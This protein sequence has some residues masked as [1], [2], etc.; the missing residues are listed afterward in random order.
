MVTGTGP[1]GSRGKILVVALVALV[2]LAGCATLVGDDGGG[3]GVDGS[4]S[5]DEG[6]GDV[7]GE[8]AGDVDSFDYPAGYDAD[9]VDDGH[10]ALEAYESALLAAGT[11][12]GAYRYVA[13]TEDGETAVSVEYAV[14]FDQERALQHVSIEAPDGDVTTDAY[15]ADGQL[16]QRSSF[17]DVDSDVTVEDEPFPEEGLTAA[18]AVGPLLTN[19]T[20]YDVTVD[21]L[22][23]D[24]V[25]IYETDDLAG[26]EALLGVEAA[27][28]VTD[29]E[30]RFVVDER[31]VV[32]ESTYTVTY[33]HDGRERIAELSFEVSALG[34]PTVVRPDWADEA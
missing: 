24:V 12:E 29:F 27:E 25:A 4:H 19:A 15:Y 10:R 8:L 9:G 22:D 5:A 23:G 20:G 2:L 34:G 13:T 1:V 21:E 17:G 33:D 26:G 30:A 31:G 18:E 7:D 32:R 14:D 11:F 3:Q 6:T 28:N 16:H